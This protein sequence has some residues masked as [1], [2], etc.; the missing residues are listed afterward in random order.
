MFHPDSTNVSWTFYRCRIFRETTFQN[1]ILCS[2]YDFQI[3]QI[4]KFQKK[5]RKSIIMVKVFSHLTILVVATHKY[6]IKKLFWGISQNSQ[7][8]PPLQESLFNKDA[9]FSNF[10]MKRYLLKKAIQQFLSTRFY[11]TRQAG[12]IMKHAK[13]V[14]SWS[15]PSMPFYEARQAHQFFEVRQPRQFMKHANQVSTPSTRARKARKHAKHASTPLSRLEIV[16]HLFS[17]ENN[18]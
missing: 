3:V 14:I 12:H 13:H 9:S 11:R 6:S 1:N 4:Q 7:K 2:K 15:I 17:C 10:I 16:T 18:R 8:K 5:F